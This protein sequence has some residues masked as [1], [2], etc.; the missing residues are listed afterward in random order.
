MNEQTAEKAAPVSLKEY[1]KRLERHDW[2][3]NQ[4][5]DIR[6]YRRGKAQMEEL[7]KAA[8]TSP[9][10]KK[11][12]DAYHESCG[13]CSLINREYYAEQLLKVRL[14]VGATTQAELDA[15]EREKR[16]REEREEKMRLDRLKA[17]DR[18]CELHD[19]FYWRCPIGY[20]AYQR[21]SEERKKLLIERGFSQKTPYYQLFMA[22]AAYWNIDEKAPAVEQSGVI[23]ALYALRRELKVII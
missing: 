21:G 1:D 23:E 4:S 7:E 6:M 3:Y 13:N 12:F 8:K 10:H 5:D 14:E 9:K 20:N 2:Y 22:W 18:L 17:F 16:E 11:L 15:I 19:W